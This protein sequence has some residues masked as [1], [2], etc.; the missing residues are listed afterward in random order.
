MPR[1]AAVFASLPLPVR[2]CLGAAGTEFRSAARKAPGAFAAEVGGLLR[3]AAR[4]FGCRTEE[5]LFL[6]GFEKLNSTPGRLEDALAELRAAEFLAAEGFSGISPLGR[7]VS[8]TADL[9]ASRAGEGYVFEVR[10]V[11]GGFGA[12]AARRLIPKFRKKA[13]QVGVSIKA[14]GIS[15]GGVI[16]VAGPPF[17]RSFVPSAALAEAAA[18]VRAGAARPRM[19][20]CLL[21]GGA[22]A[23]SPDWP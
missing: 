20:A 11:S 3:S 17:G 12:A 14:L 7:T 21:S 8:R 23:V 13:V 9:R 22:A 6:T 15:R 10:R 5:A 4:I 16:F 2:E 18:G 1:C 19:H